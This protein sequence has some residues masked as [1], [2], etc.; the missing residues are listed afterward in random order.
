MII[1]AIGILAIRYPNA[2][3]D[4]DPH[5]VHAKSAE[6]IFFML[7]LLLVVK[8]AWGKIGGSVVIGLGLVAIWYF[9]LPNKEETS[10]E[11]LA[12]ENDSTPNKA[13]RQ[14]LV[15]GGVRYFRQLHNR[16]S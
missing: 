8:F 7:V 9:I 14:A 10:S 5:Y 1:I 11:S 16:K 15:R 12:I 6:E 3:R 2:L 4:F 13:L